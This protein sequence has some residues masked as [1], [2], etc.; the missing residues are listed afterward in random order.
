MTTSAMTG[1]V[2][3][4]CR[5]VVMLSFLQDL[6]ATASPLKLH[7]AARVPHAETPSTHNISLEHSQNVSS[8]AAKA[9]AVGSAGVASASVEKL[10]AVNT[11]RPAVMSF[12]THAGSSSMNTSHLLN[13]SHGSNASYGYGVVHFLFLIG[14]RLPHSD[15]WRGFFASAP[16]GSWKALVHCKDPYGCTRSGVLANNPGFQMVPTVGTWYCHDLVTAM[17][18]LLTAALNMNAAWQG[19]REKFVFL[20]E[21][22]LPVKP[23]TQIY[24]TLLQDDD[25]DFCIFP[26]NQWASA[27]IDGRFT[28]LV[29][30]HQ[31]MVLARAHAEE[32]SRKWVPVDSRGVWQVWL[33]GGSWTGRERYVS[34]QHFYHP[35]AANWCTDEYAFLATIFGSVEYTGATKDIPGLGGSPLHLSGPQSL[36]VQGRCRTFSYW[37]N[38]EP[39]FAN[40]AGQIYHDVYGSTISCYPKCWARPA[41]LERVSDASLHALRASPFLFVRKFAE[42]AWMPNYVSIVLSA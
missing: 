40:L 2:A 34:P 12:N 21:S 5:W 26:S 4:L 24:T 28:Y 33:K 17:N 3:R 20:S 10:V 32:F 36:R 31:W 38:E 22:S 19:G 8:V 7:N 41:T 9:K 29:K 37:D 13:S 39:A 14:D 35:P 11:S 27:H 6:V 30:H 42:A 23:F 18:S 25:S 15:I 1:L 16:E